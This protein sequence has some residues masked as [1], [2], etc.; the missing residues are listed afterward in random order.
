MIF[1][2]DYILILLKILI[3]DLCAFVVARTL[4]Y[5]LFGRQI[6]KIALFGL[7]VCSEIALFVYFVAFGRA[8]LV[9][10]Q[11]AIYTQNITTHTLLS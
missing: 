1:G 11:I 9:S 7:V 4:L 6:P 8:L 10:R 5:R 3:M 2:L